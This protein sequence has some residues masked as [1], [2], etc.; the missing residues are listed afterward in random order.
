MRTLLEFRESFERKTKFQA[1]VKGQIENLRANNAEASAGWAKLRQ[2]WDSRASVGIRVHGPRDDQY[3]EALHGLID[4]L[5][6]QADNFSNLLSI[7]NEAHGDALALVAEMGNRIQA[8]EAELL[9]LK[10]EES[11]AEWETRMW[12]QSGQEIPEHRRRALGLDKK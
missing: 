9:A 3:I 11:E 7:E 2:A 10:E 6:K 12:A 4:G 5:H 1:G 8:L